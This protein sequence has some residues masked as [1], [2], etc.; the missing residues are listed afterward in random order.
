MFYARPVK[1]YYKMVSDCPY[2]LLEIYSKT[3]GILEYF[4]LLSGIRV[5]VDFMNV[6]CTNNPVVGVLSNCMNESR[7]SHTF[8]IARFNSS[9]TAGFSFL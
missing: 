8:A 2:L 5:G 9:G 3:C 4:A 7:A 6:W 1:L